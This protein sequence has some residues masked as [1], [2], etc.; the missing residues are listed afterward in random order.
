MLYVIPIKGQY[1]QYCN[2]L[3]LKELGVLGSED[4]CSNKL[5]QWIALNHILD[6]AFLDETNELIERIFKA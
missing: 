3:A 1:E 4:L 5:K 6:I 2:Y